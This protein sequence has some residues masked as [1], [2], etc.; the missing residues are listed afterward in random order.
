M[1]NMD[2]GLWWGTL[3]EKL[4]VKWLYV[5]ADEKIVIG[6]PTIYL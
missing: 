4:K 6:Q 5:D 1:S 3:V 2:I